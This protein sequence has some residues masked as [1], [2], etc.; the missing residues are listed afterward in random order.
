VFLDITLKNNTEVANG[1]YYAFASSTLLHLFST[2]NFKNDDKYLAP[3]EIFF[4]LARLCWA[5]YGPE[6]RK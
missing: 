1:R 4:A 2:S 6:G 5:G 3:P